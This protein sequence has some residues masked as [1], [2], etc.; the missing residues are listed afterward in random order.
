MA[1]F[2]AKKALAICVLSAFLLTFSPITSNTHADAGYGKYNNYYSNQ[3]SVFFKQILFQYLSYMAYRK[4]F[5][6]NIPYSP[7]GSYYNQNGQMSNFNWPNTTSPTNPSINTCP[8]A[9][10]IPL[11]VNNI[12]Y[13]VYICMTENNSQ[14]TLY[15]YYPMRDAMSGNLQGDYNLGSM[16]VPNNLYDQ[17]RTN[18][19]YNPMGSTGYGNY[20]LY[21]SNYPNSLTGRNYPVSSIYNQ[22]TFDPNG[23]LYRNYMRNVANDTYRETIQN[24]YRWSDRY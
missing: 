23:D 15:Y 4:V 1:K 2:L 12:T 9:S 13:N 20:P 7:G 5:A 8:N 24:L 11:S 22:P 6:K 10:T 16:S 19:Y 18:N 14:N 17:Y 21:G 3:D